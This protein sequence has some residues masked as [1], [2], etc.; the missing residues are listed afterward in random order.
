[1]TI[2]RNVSLLNFNTFHIEAK[3]SN[4]VEVSSE[5]EFVQLILSGQTAQNQLL[6]LGGGSNMLFTK[7]FE[8]LAIKNNIKGIQNIKEDDEHVFIKA[9][10]GEVWHEFVLHCISKNYGGLENLSLIPGSVGAGPIQ[11]IGAYGVELKDTFYECEAIRLQDGSKRVFSLEQCKFGYRE[12]VFK[13]ELKGQYFISSVTFKLSKNPTFKTDYGQIQI[14][15]DRMGIKELSVKAI[16]DAV[17][18]IRRSKL[19]NPAEIGNAGSFF[20]NPVVSKSHFA[21]IK[22]KYPDVSSYPSGENIKLAAG[23]LIEKAGWKGKTI[24]QCGVH[25]NQ[26]LVLVNYGSALGKEIFDLSEQVIHS[27]KETFDVDLEREVNI[28]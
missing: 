27:I 6:I 3:A 28:L 26:A 18:N 5:E 23:W 17:C 10:A 16:S 8:G 1:M 9:S 19:P 20:K 21:K 7:D 12:S 4:F 22:E 2:Q 13:H 14:E 15:L 11:N 25:K 24:G